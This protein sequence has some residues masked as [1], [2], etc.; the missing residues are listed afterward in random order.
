MLDIILNELRQT[1]N[2]K[3]NIKSTAREF[4][5]IYLNS[6]QLKKLQQRKIKKETNYKTNKNYD[7]YAEKY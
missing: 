1:T 2:K 4:N 3:T 5:F 6:K 7:N